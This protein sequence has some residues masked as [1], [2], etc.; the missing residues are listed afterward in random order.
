MKICT[1]FL[2]CL[3]FCRLFHYDMHQHLD[4]TDKWFL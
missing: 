1:F 4:I 2:I 3:Y